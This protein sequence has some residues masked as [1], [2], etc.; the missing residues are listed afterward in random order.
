MKNFVVALDADAGKLADC[1][2]GDKL[3]DYDPQKI[4]QC[5]VAVSWSKYRPDAIAQ[6][7]RLHAVVM[8]VVDFESMR[9]R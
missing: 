7:Q 6:A 4:M 2:M 3:G 5:R 1:W 8:T 9:D